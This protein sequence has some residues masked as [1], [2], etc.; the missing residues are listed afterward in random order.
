M[1]QGK[2]EWGAGGRWGGVQGEGEWGVGGRWSGV[3]GEGGEVP[4]LW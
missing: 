4:G 2:V 3:Q 1:V